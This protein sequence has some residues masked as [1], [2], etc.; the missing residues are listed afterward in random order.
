VTGGPR[1]RHRDRSVPPFYT[2]RIV[3][4][5]EFHVHIKP[6]D[7]VSVDH[8]LIIGRDRADVTAGVG[9]FRAAIARAL[10]AER[11]RDIA[12]LLLQL[13]DLG[14]VRRGIGRLRTIPGQRAGTGGL[15]L[16][17]TEVE[18]MRPR[19]EGQRRKAA[20]ADPGLEVGRVDLRGPL[21]EAARSLHSGGR[22]V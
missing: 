22:R 9:D 16:Q 21:F 3:Q 14:L 5:I 7:V 13:A 15:R 8:R 6:G 17:E 4:R 12:A 2:R 18:V 20:A 10:A 11:Q 1:L 19:L